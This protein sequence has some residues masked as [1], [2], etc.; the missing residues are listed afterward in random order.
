MTSRKETTIKGA[1]VF[2]IV[3]NNDE[4]LDVWHSR[5]KSL[6]QRR[7]MLAIRES[8][9]DVVVVLQDDLDRIKSI[10]GSILE[11]LM[12]NATILV[13]GIRLPGGV[14]RIDWRTTPRPPKEFPHRGVVMQ[15]LL[16]VSDEVGEFLGGR[17]AEAILHLGKQ[18][19]HGLS[20]ERSVVAL[21]CP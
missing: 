17:R 20:V 4:L 2:L 21:R 7:Q 5:L 12:G 11:K 8:T 3:V 6:D 9:D 10:P 1:I 19:E 13:F 14:I 18:V 15:V 16:K